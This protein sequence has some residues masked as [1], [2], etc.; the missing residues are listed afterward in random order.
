MELKLV[1]KFQD[2]SH[3]PDFLKLMNSNASAI[4]AISNTI[5]LM[6]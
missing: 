3:N 6:M 2:R 5:V 1:A 4:N